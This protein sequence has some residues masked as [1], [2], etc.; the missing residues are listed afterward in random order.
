MEERVG[1]KSAENVFKFFLKE[2]NIKEGGAFDGK[3]CAPGLGLDFN[4]HGGFQIVEYREGS[5]GV[6]CPFGYARH[7][8][9]EF[10]EFLHFAR[11]LKFFLD[12]Q[13]SKKVRRKLEG[14]HAV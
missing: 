7:S 3:S 10:V 11:D 12:N 1:R 4:R 14:S 2:Y 8:A 6:H 5:T 13:R 9:R